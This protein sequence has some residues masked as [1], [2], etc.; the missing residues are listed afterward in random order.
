MNSDQV[1]S[2][3]PAYVSQL[4]AN[5]ALQKLLF[6]IYKAKKLLSNN[7]SPI[8]KL[9]LELRNNIGKWWTVK[10]LADLSNMS[11]FRI[12]NLFVEYTGTTPKNYI[13]KLKM[14]RAIE[15]LSSEKTSINVIADSLGYMDP[16]H[17]SRRFKHIIGISPD[18][19]RKNVIRIDLKRNKNST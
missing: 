8:E 3:N 7:V 13:E 18:S 14:Q 5:I 9:I 12:R 4:S 16:Y 6:E 19:Y 17:F 1:D 10:V 15:M 2:R 11:I